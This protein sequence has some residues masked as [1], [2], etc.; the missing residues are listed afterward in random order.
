MNI[1]NQVLQG[2]ITRN[3]RGG[4]ARSLIVGGVL[5]ALAAKAARHYGTQPDAPA[6]SPSTQPAPGATPA[7]G[8]LGSLLGPGGLGGLLGSLGGAGALGAL[9][10]QLQREGL[11]KQANSWIGRGANE[12]VAPAQL[13][14]ALGEGDIA[15]LQAQ[16]GMPREELLSSLSQTLPEAVD[17]LTPEGRLPATDEELRQT[18]SSPG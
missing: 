18:A 9:L 15:E 16:T 11:G 3:G 14:A 5:L 2:G 1:L 10:T 7:P 4:G 17:E 6:G 12:P 13:A 8:G